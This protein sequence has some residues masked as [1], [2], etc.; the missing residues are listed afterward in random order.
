MADWLLS[1]NLLRTPLLA[2]QIGGL[3]AH[4]GGHTCRVSAVLRSLGLQLKGLI[5]PIASKPA[6]WRKLQADGRF[7][8]IQ[9]LDNLS[10]IV[11]CFHKAVDLMCFNLAEMIIIYGQLRLVG[12]EALNAKHFQQPSAQLIKVALCT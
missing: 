9:Q 7:V 4:R 11:S 2:K 8:S 6:V 5:E 1:I 12:Q 3:L 10:L